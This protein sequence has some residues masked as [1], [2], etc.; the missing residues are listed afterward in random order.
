MRHITGGAN[1]VSL[2]NNA[3]EAA[4]KGEFVDDGPADVDV[5][6]FPVEVSD[7]AGG[8]V[9]LLSSHGWWGA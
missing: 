4:E 1:E 2:P 7:L 6:D 8:V 9:E 3:D 5:D